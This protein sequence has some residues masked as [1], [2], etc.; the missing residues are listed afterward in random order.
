MQETGTIYIGTSGW[1]YN[2]WKGKFYPEGVTPK[3][4]TEYYLRFFRTVEINNS[5][6]RLPSAETFATWRTSVPPDFLF[7]VKASR[8]ITHMKK[9]KDPQQ[10]LAQFLGNALALEEKLG[11]ILFQLP[12]VWRLNLERFHDFLKA[13]PPYHRYT[14]EFRDQSWYNPEVFALL[15]QYNHAFCIYDLAGHL[16]PL[17]VTAGFVYVRLHGP[18][19]KYAGSY[20]EETLQFWASHC[21]TWAAAGKDVFVYFDNDIGSHAPFNAIA[22]Q[23]LVKKNS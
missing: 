7:S 11:P 1:H 12:P 15:Q 19:G 16:S 23:E 6:Y 10:S 18:E 22:L 20:S 5:F 17:E 14:F 8:Y 9:L 3:Q 4:F 21:R 2:H 13:L